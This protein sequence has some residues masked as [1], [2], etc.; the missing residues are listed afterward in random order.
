MSETTQTPAKPAKAV[1]PIMKTTA[2]TLRAVQPKRFGPNALQSVGFGATELMT[3]EAPI[4][5][6]Y[7]E[8]ILPITWST[9]AAKIA[10]NTIDNRNPRDGAG[11]LIILDALD[12]SFQAWLRVS[13]VVRDQM[14]NPCGLEVACIGPSIDLKTGEACPIDLKTR[15]A[16]VDAPKPEEKVA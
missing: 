16:W 8:A 6:T 14:N 1:P 4:G 10:K 2:P 11:V 3:I 9:V 5:M 7:A 12:G 13:K 15:K